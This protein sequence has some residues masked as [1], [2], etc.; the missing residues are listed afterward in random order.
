MHFHLPYNVEK[1]GF[2]FFIFANCVHS[3][4]CHSDFISDPSSCQLKS[5]NCFR[6]QQ[7]SEVCPLSNAANRD[8][9]L[10]F[11][12]S[13]RFS[14]SHLS[15]VFGNDTENHSVSVIRPTQNNKIKRKKRKRNARIVYKHLYSV[16]ICDKEKLAYYQKKQRSFRW[17][18]RSSPSTVIVEVFFF[19]VRTTVFRACF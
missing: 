16:V 13:F 14:T 19:F 5:A 3:H 15:N 1:M 12:C 11:S 8:Y 4:V 9:L 18:A 6:K 10:Q 2:E 7:S 17:C